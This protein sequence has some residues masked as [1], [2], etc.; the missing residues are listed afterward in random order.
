MNEALSFACCEYGWLVQIAVICY[1]ELHFRIS[2]AAKSN[3]TP[4]STQMN[5]NITV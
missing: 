2:Q 4:T 3:L 1:R 5:L